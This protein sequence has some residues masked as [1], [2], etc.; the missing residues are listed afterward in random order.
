MSF[1]TVLTTLVGVL[2]LANLVL[3]VGRTRRVTEPHQ[4]VED[5]GGAPPGHPLA[6]ADL[7]D[8]PPG[9]AVTVA[10]DPRS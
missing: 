8:S 2:G 7:A 10:P 9:A 3:V 1:S 5:L 6:D 4:G